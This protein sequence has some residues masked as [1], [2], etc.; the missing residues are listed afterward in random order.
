MC[1]TAGQGTLAA[2]TYFA[3]GTQPGALHGATPTGP[4]MAHLLTYMPA[5]R[6]RPATDAVTVEVTLTARQYLGFYATVTAD[7]G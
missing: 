1:F 7:C 2:V 6:Q 5:T 4:R 3:T